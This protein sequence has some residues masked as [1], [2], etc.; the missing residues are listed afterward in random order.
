MEHLG[1]EG[2]GWLKEKLEKSTVTDQNV[3]HL[4]TRMRELSRNSK[5]DERH[6]CFGYLERMV[7]K[8]ISIYT[9][10]CSFTY[11]NIYI[12]TCIFTFIYTLCLR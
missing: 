5:L 3:V 10:I 6:L 2:L 9:Y 7:N 11:I 4:W 8:L 1:E 12:Y